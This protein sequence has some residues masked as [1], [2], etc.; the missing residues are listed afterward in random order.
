MLLSTRMPSSST[1]KLFAHE[2]DLPDLADLID[3]LIATDTVPGRQTLVEHLP[4]LREPRLILAMADAVNRIA[5][6]DLSRAERLADAA[7]WLAELSGDGQCRARLRRAVGNMLVLRGEYAAALEMFQSSLDLFH[8][9]DEEMGEAATLS[10]SLQPLIYLGRYSEAIERAEK[11]R[12]IAERH[13]DEL[14]L[15]RLDINFGNIMHRQDR[16]RE[17]VSHY[18]SALT[19]LDRLGQHR[20]CAIAW[21]NLAVCYISLND[22]LAA[23]TAYQSARSISERENMPT[24]TA[25][26]DYNVAYLYYHRGEYTQA[27]QLYQKT[28]SYCERVG[29]QYHSA[30]CDLDQAEMYLEL[31]LN[32]EGT[33]LGQQALSSFEKMNMGYEAAKAL[34]WLA[35]A[36]YQSKKPFQALELFVRSQEMMAHDQ[37]V[38]WVAVLDFYKALILH[39]EGRFHEALRTCRASQSV[40]STFPESDKTV[41]AELLRSSIHLGLGEISEAAKWSNAATE[42]SERLQSP[43]LLSQAMWIQGRIEEARTSILPACASYR[44]ALQYL[45]LAPGR[46]FAEGLKLTFSRNRSQIYEA[47][48]SLSVSTLSGNP[49]VEI[50]FE[51]AEKAKSRDLAD[52]LAFRANTLPTPSRNRSALVEKVKKLREGLN[53]YYRQA[54]QADYRSAEDPAQQ[55]QLRSLI[56]GQEEGL[57]KTLSDLRVTEEEFHALQ[58]ASIT[59]ID[60]IRGVLRE[61]ELI[62]EFYQARGLIYAFLLCRDNLQVMPLSRVGAVRDLLRSLQA[63]FAKFDLGKE[64]TERFAQGLSDEV[65]SNLTKLH[66]ELIE[67]IRQHLENYRLIIIPDGPLH[68]LPFHALFDGSRYLGEDH[69]ISYA[70]S[71]SLYYLSSRRHRDLSDHDLILGQ[72]SD[73]DRGTAFQIGQV[74]RGTGIFR[75]P[76][77]DV[78]TLEEHGPGSR[79][80]HLDSRLTVREDN[81]LFSTL[82]LED[83]EISILDIYHLRLPCSLF[84]LTG[85]GPGLRPS[86]NGEEVHVLA[87][88]LEYAGAETLLMPLWNVSGNPPEQFLKEFYTRAESESDKPLVFQEAIAQVRKQFPNP[89]YWSSY[90]LRGKTGRSPVS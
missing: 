53:W 3:Q 16:F 18:K 56:R 12:E 33:Q 59:S 8:S 37:N 44:S 63:Q 73:K 68:Y 75:G 43:F 25:Q 17:A 72:E 2:Q 71:S 26:A 50:I 31:H 76:R 11:A 9:I 23:E 40:F 62:V 19:I 46:T 88:G 38:I 32:L 45:E 85:T 47:L 64:Y 69:V 61:D 24:I 87:R 27:I 15:A 78:A 70:G 6:E 14:L 29:D 89:Y 86:G 22:F 35:I 55:A 74:L 52:L 82:S 90:I 54:D 84:G 48:V 60:K 51:T 67:P 34:V 30:L 81:P 39:Q 80:I 4:R 28:R 7:N 10:S 77:A 1:T 57:V 21:V 13:H 58:S 49:D 5:R 42:R 36:A 20:D 79:F 83:K 65:V 66:R 41:Y